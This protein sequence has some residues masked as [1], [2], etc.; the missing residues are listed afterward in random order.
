[1][2]VDSWTR[3]KS[4]GTHKTT[5]QGDDQVGWKGQEHA[6]GNPRHPACTLTTGRGCA[7]MGS[8]QDQVLEDDLASSFEHVECEVSLK[9][10]RGAVRETQPGARGEVKPTTL[11]RAVEARA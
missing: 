10:P 1:M 8:M 5:E 3:L 2:T 9:H 11:G 6:S 7:A 4:V